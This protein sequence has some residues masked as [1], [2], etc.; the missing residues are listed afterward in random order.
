MTPYVR[1][2]FWGL[3]GCPR[4]HTVRHFVGHWVYKMVQNLEAGGQ[5]PFAPRL[6]S[7]CVGCPR[8]KWGG[9]LLPLSA[10]SHSGHLVS[11]LVCIYN[12]VCSAQYGCSP[13]SQPVPSLTV[14]CDHLSCDLAAPN[15]ASCITGPPS[16]PGLALCFPGSK[17]QL[18]K[19]RL[20]DA[21]LL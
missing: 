13:L 19:C 21:S 4:L 17:G 14:V 15:L 2:S 5:Q 3:W 11:R 6:P 12:T 20:S 9:F 1:R 16:S 18:L 8:V 7:I 10:S